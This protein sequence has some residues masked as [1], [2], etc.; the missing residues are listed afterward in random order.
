AR[1][2]DAV[3]ANLVEEGR[4]ADIFGPLLRDSLGKPDAGVQPDQGVEVV[5][6]VAE[7]KQGQPAL[8]DVPGGDWLR[9]QEAAHTVERLKKARH[10]GGHRNSAPAPSGQAD[11][12]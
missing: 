8:D 5:E 6:A 12:P 2:G 1:I 7:T 4:D 10:R 3:A 11:A 9:R